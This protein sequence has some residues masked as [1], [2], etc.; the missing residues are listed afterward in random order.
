MHIDDVNYP[1]WQ[2][3]ITGIKNWIF[4]PPAECMFQCTT[5]MATV[6]PGDIIVFDSNR[7]FHS[8]EIVGNDLSL[9]VGS[10]YD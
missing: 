2:A 8:T 1:S 6:K 10:E 4:K 5:L 9:T 3:Q 7:W